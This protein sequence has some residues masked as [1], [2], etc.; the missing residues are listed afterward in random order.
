V[1]GYGQYCPIARASEIF[2]ER[3][4]PIILRNVF[5]GCR[6][7]TEISAGAPGLSHTLLTQRLRQ[8]ER[9]GVIERRPAPEGRGRLYF[10]TPAGEELDAV[11]LALGTWGARWLEA[12]PEDLGPYVVLW[13]ASRLLDPADLPSQRV[14]I[15]FDF[16]AMGRPNRFWLVLARG[17]AE[18]CVKP[19]GFED[20][21]VVTADAEWFA[22]WHMGL[23]SWGELL[24]D[25]RVRVVGPAKLAR[26]LPRWVPLSRFANVR[27]VAVA[28]AR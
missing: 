9:V 25:G 1:R 3:W 22:K 14:V 20:D 15:R 10:P 21:V 7:F 12:A 4:T 17:A 23:A 13:A 5:L 11:C 6:T 2:A 8:L 26:S 19:P 28:V 27:P 24:R 16:P 18:V